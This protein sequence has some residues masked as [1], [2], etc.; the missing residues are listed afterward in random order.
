VRY[1]G[2]RRHSKPYYSLVRQG[3]F[4]GNPPVHYILAEDNVISITCSLTWVTNVGSGPRFTIFRLEL[5]I[6]SNRAATLRFVSVLLPLL[7][8]SE[9]RT[10]LSSPSPGGGVRESYGGYTEQH[11]FNKNSNLIPVA[12][13]LQQLY[14]GRKPTCDICN[15]QVFSS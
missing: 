12:V 10:S 14:V 3:K 4:I 2:I 9:Y 1:Y 5:A 15:K 13:L 8:A 7:F 11:I 6:Y